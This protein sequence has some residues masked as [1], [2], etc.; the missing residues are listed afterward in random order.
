MFRDNVPTFPDIKLNLGRYLGPATDVGS[1]LTANILK[2]NGQTVCRST[3]WHLNDK[4]IHYPMHQIIHRVF[5]ESITNHLGPNVT[6]QD[7]PAEDLTPDYSFYDNNHDL[8]LDHG[9]LEM[10]PKM[11]DNYLSAEIS[12]PCGGTLVKGHITSR[13]RDKDNNPIGLTNANPILGTRK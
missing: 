13:K 1:A 7:F 2:S 9:N 10:T 12:V 6:E 8:D 11:G 4:E 5:N 3:L